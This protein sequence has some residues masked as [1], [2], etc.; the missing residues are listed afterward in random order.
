VGPKSGYTTIDSLRQSPTPVKFGCSGIGS[1]TFFDISLV[2]NALDINTEII[3]G[4]GGSSETRLA[5]LRG[6]L[7]AVVSDFSSQYPLIKSKDLIPV[8]HYGN[9]KMAELE[10][11]PNVKDLP[12]I[13]EDRQQLLD[14]VVVFAS[15]G[16]TVVAPPGVAPE[17]AAFLT[18]AIKTS[19]EEPQFIKNAKKRKMEIKYMSPTAVIELVNKGLKISPELQNRIKKIMGR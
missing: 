12:G 4:Y 8:T 13:D 3:T 19:I 11:I 10:G 9:V 6:E 15:L 14:I 7:H 18:T 17:R 16:R 5:V 2:G 1:P